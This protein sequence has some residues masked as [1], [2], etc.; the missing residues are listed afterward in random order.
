LGEFL[1]DED[2]EKSERVM[3]AM[4]EM[5]KLDIKALRRAYQG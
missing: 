5:D 2:E 4:L 1:N 3:K